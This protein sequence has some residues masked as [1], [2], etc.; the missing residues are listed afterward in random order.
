M[1]RSIVSLT[2]AGISAESGLGTFRDHDGL[3][4]RYDLH[5]VATPQGFSRNPALV[6]DFYN[7]RRE[8]CRKSTPNA[9]HFAVDRLEKD[10][11]G[12]VQIITQ[13]IDDLHERAGSRAVVHMHGEI[14]QALCARCRHRWPAPL[15]LHTDDACPA[16]S[17]LGVRP[18]VV[19]FGEMP[20]HLD[21]IQA[22]LQSAD[23]FV[24]IGTSSQVFPA[25]AFVHDAA[26]AGAHTLELNLEPSDL[27]QVFAERR[28]GPAS[29]IV[30]E[31]VDEILERLP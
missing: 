23:L 18:D 26:A 2:G 8:N 9:A 29:R 10:Y 17:A 4:S 11:P 27:S 7:E 12:S 25:A 28:Y 14:G 6:H 20:Y 24:A 3:W 19:W 15:H 16:C 22:A 31:W 30:P 21:V 5:D 1:G 13:N